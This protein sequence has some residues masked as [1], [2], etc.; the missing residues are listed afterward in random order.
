M[1]RGQEAETEMEKIVYMIVLM[2]GVLIFS[3]CEANAQSWIPSGFDS[4]MEN[5]SK[6]EC[7]IE[8]ELKKQGLSPEW[9]A[10]AIAESGCKQES[11]SPAGA[12]GL[13]QL[14]P[15][16]ARSLGLEVTEE[17]DERLDV[18]KST[19][20]AAVYIKHLLAMFNG[21][22]LWALAGYNVGG[23][24]LKKLANYPKNKD[25]ETLRKL[26]PE[27]YNL[28]KTTAAIMEA[29]NQTEEWKCR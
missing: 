21:N 24:N 4:Y 3:C 2:L 19:R 25:F 26:A 27:A 5:C 6:V 14:M 7:E 23:R 8:N 29:L 10:L 22:A 11:E 13:W 1:E 17:S 18:Q 12:K 28:A 16:T 9:M 15:S 20:A